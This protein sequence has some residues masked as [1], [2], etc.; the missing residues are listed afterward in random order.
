MEGFI[1]LIGAVIFLVAVIVGS[2]VYESFSWGFVCF[3]FWGWFVL[4]VFTTLPHIT[5]WQA[6][7]LMFFISLFK[8]LNY[9][10]YNHSKDKEFEKVKLTSS[11]I[12]PWI[13]L[14]VGYGIG[15]Y[16]IFV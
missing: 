6:I 12:A 14:L 8:A 16:F 13:T 4:P 10:S 15:Y 11:L 9:N 5:F 2:V 3:K 7:G 1:L